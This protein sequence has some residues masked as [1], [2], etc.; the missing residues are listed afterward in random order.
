M[1][2]TGKD[3]SY[4]RAEGH[5]MDPLLQIGKDGLS[6]ST[7]EKTEELLTDH[8]LIKIRVLDNNQLSA[9]ESAHKLADETDS[10]VVQVIGHVAL[11]YRENP[12]ISGYNIPQ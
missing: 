7:I 11:L 5:G 1:E 3:R 6:E 4:L 9:R 12:E 8:E 2:L 10:S